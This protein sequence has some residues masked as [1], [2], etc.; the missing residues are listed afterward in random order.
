MIA[1]NSDP[2]TLDPAWDHLFERLRSEVRRNP[3][4]DLA[5][6]ANRAANR[7]EVTLPSFGLLSVPPQF[8]L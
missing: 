5:I 7:I 6:L 2:Q 8:R 3:T 4:G 1:T